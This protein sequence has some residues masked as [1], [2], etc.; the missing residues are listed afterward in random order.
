MCTIEEIMLQGVKEEQLIHEEEEKYNI[1]TPNKNHGIAIGL[2]NGFE[3]AY[4][5]KI[6]VSKDTELLYLELNFSENATIGMEKGDMD[7]FV[8]IDYRRIRYE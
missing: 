3:I 5:T 7:D 4:V 2:N 6:M 8:V 1:Y